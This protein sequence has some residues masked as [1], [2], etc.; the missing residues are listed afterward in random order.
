[1]KITYIH[2]SGFL[3]ETREVYYLFDYE[4]GNLPQLNTEKPLFVFVS[5]GHSDHYNPQI[6]DLLRSM[7]MKQITALL[8]NDIPKKRYPTCLMPSAPE[9][10]DDIRRQGLIPVIKAYHSQKYALSFQ[11]HVQ[12]LLSTDKGVAFFL[13]CPEG[14]LYHAGDLNDWTIEETPEQERRQMTGSYLAAIKRLEGNNID[15]AFLPLDP[16]LGKYYAKG[17]LTFLE[18]IPVKQV[19]PM[20]YWDHPEIIKQFLQE[21]PQYT[22]IIVT[23]EIV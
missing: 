6:F 7:G 1:M 18:L 17:F 4:K 2:H 20:H 5:H 19:Y 8:S 11:T 14:T 10:A 13:T 9:E 16:R 15:I 12:T 23:P 3:A 22:N 21:Y